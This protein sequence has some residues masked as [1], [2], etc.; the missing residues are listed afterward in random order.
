[1]KRKV[2][3]TVIDKKLLSLLSIILLLS[4]SSNEPHVDYV[5]SWKGDGIG[6]SVEVTSPKD[7]ILFTYASR[8]VA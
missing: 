5:L 2:K 6:V 4:C 3:V 8:Q 1:M 7:T